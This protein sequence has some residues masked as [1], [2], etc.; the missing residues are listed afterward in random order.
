MDSAY[1]LTAVTQV[2]N[3]AADAL[4]TELPNEALLVQGWSRPP[5]E[6]QEVVLRLSEAVPELVDT[7]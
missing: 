4:Y 6:L 7:I 5:K 2:R 3:A 1:V